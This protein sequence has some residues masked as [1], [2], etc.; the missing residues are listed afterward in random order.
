MSLTLAVQFFNVQENIVRSF[1]ADLSEKSQYLIKIESINIEWWDRSHVSQ[2]KVFDLNQNLMLTFEDVEIEFNLSNLFRQESVS[3]EYIYFDKMRVNLIKYEESDVFNLQSFLVALK[4]DDRVVQSDLM[5]HIG[6]MIFKDLQVTINDH[7]LDNSILVSSPLNLNISHLNMLDIMISPDSIGFYVDSLKADLSI[8]PNTSITDLNGSFGFTRDQIDLSEMHLK[9][10]ETEINSEISLRLTHG[11]W[12]EFKRDSVFINMNLLPSIIDSKDFK[13]KKYLKDHRRISLELQMEGYMNELRLSSLSGTLET[14]SLLNAQGSINGM[15]GIDST[16]LTLEIIDSYW[17]QEDLRVYLKEYHHGPFRFAGSIQGN[18]G[19]MLILGKAINQ[20]GNIDLDLNLMNL[21]SPEKISYHGKVDF[22]DFQLGKIIDDSRLG[23]S[24]GRLIFKGFGM[25]PKTMNS[26]ILIQLE[27]FVFL[28]KTYQNVDLALN[29]ESNNYE[30]SFNANDKDLKM[31]GE[32][33]YINQQSPQLEAEVS[34]NCANLKAMNFSKDTLAFSLNA[35]ISI[36]ELKKSGLIGT[37]ILDDIQIFDK[38][39][40]INFDP[41]YISIDTT[42][43]ERL[44]IENSIFNVSASGNF[45][46]YTVISDWIAEARFYKDQLIF[47][48]KNLNLLP[49]NDY[50]IKLKGD[51]EDLAYIGRLTELNKKLGGRLSIDL[52]YQHGTSFSGNISTELLQLDTLKF[53]DNQMEFYFR[54]NHSNSLEGQVMLSSKKQRWFHFPETSDFNISLNLFSDTLIGD[55]KIGQVLKNSSLS[56]KMQSV[57]GS[58]EIAVKFLTSELKWLDKIWKISKGNQIII[59]KKSVMLKDFEISND[60]DFIGLDGLISNDQSSKLFFEIAN[61]DLQNIASV[62]PR[63]WDGILSFTGKI[64]RLNAEQPW[65]ID[66]KLNLL[67]LQFEKV[68]IGDLEGSLGWRPHENRLYADFKIGSGSNERGRLFGYVFP[69]NQEDQLSLNMEFKEMRINWLAPL[70]QKKI[71]GIDGYA[72]GKLGIQ[73]SVFNP[74]IN[75]EAILSEGVAT[76]DYLN[77]DYKF[78]GTTQFDQN[79]IYF[80]QIEI[81]DRFGS[82][83]F[84]TGQVTH[85]NIK[86]K[87]LDLK[88]DFL[89]LELLNT[90]HNQN[91]LYYGNAFGSGE[92]RISGPFNN[93]IFD[94]NIQTNGKTR[95]K[96]PI[97]DQM[98]FENQDY[99]NFVNQPDIITMSNDVIKPK[100]SN[101][102]FQVNMNL[103]ITRDA[104]GEL[105]FNEQTGD[106]IRGRGQGNL[107]LSVNSDGLFEV[108]GQFEVLEGAYNWTSNV[109]NKEF[110]I[111]PGGMVSFFGDPYQG[112][113]SLE[114]NYRQLVDLS[115]WAG[116]SQTFGKKSPIL[117]VLK[118]DGPVINPEIDFE[119]KFEENSTVSNSDTDWYDIL[120]AINSNEQELKRQVF[121]LLILRQLSPSNQLPSTEQIGQGFGNSVSEF[122]SNQLSYWLNQVDDN[123]EVS[124]DL[125]GLDESAVETVELR[126]AYTFLEGRLRLAGA[127]AVNNNQNEPSSTNNIL[128]DWSFDYFL[129]EDGRLRLKIFRQNNPYNYANE[130]SVE[131]GI[132]LQYV[133]SFDKLKGLFINDT[134]K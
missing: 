71:S 22:D 88:V 43:L 60:L 120:T 95:I 123:L 81:F 101:R 64:E 94:A 41:I 42:E 122:I 124:V 17:V 96:I 107:Q 83:G 132:S 85:E 91:T 115:S 86:G 53:L 7:L 24:G 100:N 121:S 27:D 4:P 65:Q 32:G 5:C 31:R 13:L 130:N 102:G 48:Q 75:G 109:L 116:E 23:K 111:Q 38:G 45:P 57:F 69:S 125:L 9:L 98:N 50:K 33:V 2:I 89:N 79:I 29:K 55:I 47:D 35:K 36:K 72:S 34:L 104:Y 87:T 84:V 103:E 16:I 126:L 58:E 11:N 93:L 20:Y 59:S 80:D 105:I 112:L 67:K 46:I 18:K 44:K 1:V 54:T 82:K 39:E 114:A 10:G 78:S 21:L 133:K 25:D 28:N 14:G 52:A 19:E 128:G 30:F 49:L 73:G 106:I 62:L 134:K 110:E 66:G 118:L 26:N 77:T 63:K 8:F 6:S 127:S 40:N 119:L 108:L 92:V 3:L 15:V 51:L 131:G 76:V 99:I 97:E 37:F 90:S 129:T 113:M 117:V 74:K 56:L 68:E 12:T 70:F 61:F